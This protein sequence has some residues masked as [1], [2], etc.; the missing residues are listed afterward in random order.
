[1]TDYSQTFIDLGY[2][3][4]SILFI[5]GIKMLG[6]PERARTGNM[7]SALGMLIAVVSVLLECCL[8]FEWVIIGLLIG[9]VIGAVSARLV[10]MTAMP[11]MVAVLNGFGGI[12]SLL[13][14]WENYHSHPDSNLMIRVAVLLAVLIGGV[15]FSGS[16]VAYAKLAGRI[17]GRPVS[18]SRQQWVNLG[19]LGLILGCGALLIYHPIG[20]LPYV[21]FI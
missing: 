3:V 1:M 10:Q 18:F 6:R 7:V 9:S 17:S 8:S 14:G 4:A 19:I 13:V 21:I 5:L 2:I 15:A 20:A 11:Q 12:A 16:L